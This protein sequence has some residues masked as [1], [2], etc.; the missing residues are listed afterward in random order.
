MSADDTAVQT[1]KGLFDSLAGKAKEMFG[2]LSGNDSV[3]T[4]GQLQQRQAQDRK[5]ANS[6]QSLADAQAEEA[7]QDLAQARNEGAEQRN[8]VANRAAADTTE[9]R[10]DQATDPLG[11]H[12]GAVPDASQAEAEATAAR[13]RADSLTREEGLA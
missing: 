2:A 1:R 7:A 5:E 13:H 9:V 8:E 6:T 10:V 11:K 12:E 3:T 4:E